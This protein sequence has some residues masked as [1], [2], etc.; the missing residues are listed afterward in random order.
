[1]RTPRSNGVLVSAGRWA[2]ECYEQ[3]IMTAQLKGPYRRVV[4]V[5]PTT[6]V[7]S[8]YVVLPGAVIMHTFGAHK[9]HDAYERRLV[10]LGVP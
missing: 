7:A 1:M 2:G 5:L 6:F 8:S 4:S 3:G 9:A 10:E